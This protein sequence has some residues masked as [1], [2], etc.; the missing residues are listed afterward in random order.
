MYQSLGIMQ[1]K[2]TPEGLHPGTEPLRWKSTAFNA[3][4]WGSVV[5]YY[6]DGLCYWCSPD[7]TPG[8]E[9]ASIGAWYSPLT[10]EHQLPGLR[11]VS[12][13]THRPTD[14]DPARVLTKHGPDPEVEPDRV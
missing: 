3:D 13:G 6:Y 10:L 12:Q 2:W 8:Q 11:R 4:Y 7:Y 14:L 9:W 1:V 5:R